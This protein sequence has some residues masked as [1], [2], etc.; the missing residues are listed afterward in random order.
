MIDMVNK[1]KSTDEERY[2]PYYCSKRAKHSVVYRKTIIGGHAKVIIRMCDEHFYSAK[3]NIDQRNPLYIP[4]SK[5]REN[6]I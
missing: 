2:I 4:F 3:R 5:Y 6:R 1:H